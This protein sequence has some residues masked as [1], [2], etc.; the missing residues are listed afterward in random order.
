MEDEDGAETVNRK[1]GRT[2]DFGRALWCGFHG[3]G[4]ENSKGAVE[5]AAPFFKKTKERGGTLPRHRVWGDSGCC[6]CM[7]GT[8]WREEVG[9]GTDGRDRLVSE[10]EE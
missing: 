1:E 10:V 2:V 5:D 3:E 7:S 8:R 9:E 6:P 4:E